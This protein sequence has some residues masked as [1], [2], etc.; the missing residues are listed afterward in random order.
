M[1]IS[2]VL[3][4]YLPK[5]ISDGKDPA[6]LVP[7]VKFIRSRNLCWEKKQN[8]TVGARVSEARSAQ[9]RMKFSVFSCLARVLLSSVGLGWRFPR[10]DQQQQ[11]QQQLGIYRYASCLAPTTDTLDETGCHFPMHSQ[12]S[13]GSVKK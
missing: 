6:P 9:P 2:S 4:Q 8:K 1:P 7:R 10:S 11:Q 13:S 3:Q 12:A 5:Q